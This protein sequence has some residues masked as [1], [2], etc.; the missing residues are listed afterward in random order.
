MLRYYT[1]AIAEQALSY[2][3]GGK[4]FYH[5][6][7]RLMK[8]DQGASE[9]TVSSFPLIRQ[10][11]KRLSP[12]S[13]AM[14]M[15]T[16]WFHH[17]AILL[18]LCCDDVTVHLFDIEAKALVPYIHNYVRTLLGQVDRL[19]EELDLNPNVA[20]DKLDSI[21]THN[22]LRDI[23]EQCQFIPS[24]QPRPFAPWLPEES[25]DW[26]VSNCVIN[27]IPPAM[28]EPELNALQRMLKPD[29]AMYHLIG[30]D[31]HWS[32]HDPSANMFNCYRYSDRCYRHIFETKLEYQNRMVKGEW[33]ALFERLGMPL[34]DY[35]AVVTAESRQAIRDL[36]LAPRYRCWPLE[37]L[38]I[39]HSYV[40]LGP[41]RHRE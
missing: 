28:L 14:E 13:I 5:A 7:G 36:P 39:I 20:H 12:G 22:T 17:D 11:K 15:G 16:G 19:G 10:A 26:I 1:W 30:H 37:D 29:G 18:Y 35:T 3:P 40:M 34:L 4:L 25:L 6:V 31:D 21:L 8:R 38:A 33:L 2:T 24:I 9:S 23:Y 32:F 41:A 27:H